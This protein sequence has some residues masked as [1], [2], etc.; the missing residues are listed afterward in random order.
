MEKFRKSFLS[1]I[2]GTVQLLISRMGK[3]FMSYLISGI[4]SDDIIISIT[5]IEKIT[6]VIESILMISGYCYIISGIV[7]FVLAVFDHDGSCIDSLFTNVKKVYLHTINDKFRPKAIRIKIPND[8]D[9]DIQSL[10]SPIE[11]AYDFVR[12]K[13]SKFH[14]EYVSTYYMLTP[15]VEEVAESLKT[16]IS[17]YEKAEG[18]GEKEKLKLKLNTACEDVLKQTISYIESEMGKIAE[19]ESRYEKDYE[20]AQETLERKT[21][22]KESDPFSQLANLN[23]SFMEEQERMKKYDTGTEEEETK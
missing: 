22:V 13:N 21:P 2:G 19:M 9:V 20:N 10:L 5:M 23:S 15:Y 7:Y 16:W 1:I 14:Q 6:K 12:D 3:E 18:E 17:Q 8:L 4:S 11:Q